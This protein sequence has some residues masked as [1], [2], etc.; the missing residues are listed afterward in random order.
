M[1]P[2]KV[3]GLVFNKT[4]KTNPVFSV[5]VF[6][7]VPLPGQK[8]MLLRNDFAVEERRQRRKLLCQALDLEVAA[9]I[10]IL[11][12]DV[13]KKIGRT[14]VA[15]IVNDVRHNIRSSRESLLSESSY[16]DPL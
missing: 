10:R 16:L 6:V 11:E 14:F 9:Q 4:E 7:G 2:N 5:D 15:K 3:S 13:L 12:V 1:A 8:R